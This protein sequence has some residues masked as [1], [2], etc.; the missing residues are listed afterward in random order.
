[1]LQTLATLTLFSLSVVTATAAETPDVRAAQAQMLMRINPLLDGYEIRIIPFPNKWH[2]EGA[3][4]NAIEADLAR[5]LAELMASADTEIVMELELDAPMAAASGQLIGELRDR[6]TKARLRQ[7]LRWQTRNQPLDVK[8]EVE[9]GVVRLHGQVGNAATKDR[10]AA[11]AA[12]TLGV[13]EVFNYISVDPALIPKEREAEERAKAEE[14]ADDWIAPRLLRLLASDT[15]VNARAIDM[16]V[17]SGRVILS[18][19]VSSVAERNV[20]ESLAEYIPGVR[21]VDSHL[22]IERQL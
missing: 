6:T 18:G 15:R 19:S 4:S 10:L 13:D 11:M 21:E 3:V 22:V 7:R 9:K 2:L 5:E 14:N 1:M 16:A 8:M 17:E 12:S 20:A